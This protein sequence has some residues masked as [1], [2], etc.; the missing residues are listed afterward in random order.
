MPVFCKILLVLCAKG[1][2]ILRGRLAS[3]SPPV[4]GRPYS[5]E[6]D[7]VDPYL[8]SMEWLLLHGCACSPEVAQIETA[9]QAY[10]GAQDRNRTLSVL[11][12]YAGRPANLN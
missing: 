2:K 7:S 11:A 10:P 9:V 6:K 4:P 12:G 3:I 1:R 8:S 5:W